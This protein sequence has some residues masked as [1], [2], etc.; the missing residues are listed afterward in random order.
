MGKLKFQTLCASK[1]FLP[2]DKSETV[3]NQSDLN[4]KDEP[5]FTGPVTRA[6]KKLLEQQKATNLVI[7]VLCV[8]TKTHCSTCEWEQECSDNPLLFNPDF[9]CLFIKERKS[10]LINKQSMYAKCKL[11][12]G[13]HLI[14][15][16]NDNT[17]NNI[18]ISENQS[19]GK[20]CHDFQS[21]AE[22][23]SI[24]S[25]PFQEFNSKELIELQNALRE[26]DTNGQNIIKSDALKPSYEI[27]LNYNG[28]CNHY[29]TL[30]TNFW[31]DNVPT[32]SS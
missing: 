28:L 32:F 21:D 10:W 1:S 31:A 2:E 9:A 11:Q 25:F 29:Y 15:H 12:L 14:N 19:L 3:S 20:Q 16:Q 18:D 4:F 26:K 6:M 5:K 8:L 7:S 27:F 30:P 24:H 22:P 23:N 13:E 17:A